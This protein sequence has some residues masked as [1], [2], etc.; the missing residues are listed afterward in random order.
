MGLLQRLLP[1]RHLHPTS[2]PGARRKMLR[3]HRALEAPR[4]RRP[5]AQM[6]ASTGGAKAASW[7]ENENATGSGRGSGSGPLRVVALAVWPPL[8]M[9]RRHAAP[10]AIDTTM[11]MIATWIGT[12]GARYRGVA[13][14]AHLR[15][16]ETEIEIETE[17]E[18]D[19]VGI[20][21]LGAM[22]ETETEIWIGMGI[23]RDRAPQLRLVGPGPAL[24]TTG[25]HDT[26]IATTSPTVGRIVRMCD[27]DMAVAPRPAPH[28]M[29]AGDRQD[30]AV[31]GLPAQALVCAPLRLAVWIALA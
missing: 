30:G 10:A 22:T 21:T 24:P 19:T 18:T 20:A 5:L 12:G 31:A 29:E 15:M 16:T 11:T 13:D 1:A 2:T 3:Q 17:I 23:V 26:M 27:M 9:T 14:Q 25:P 6:T 4:A 8:G 7:T 28:P